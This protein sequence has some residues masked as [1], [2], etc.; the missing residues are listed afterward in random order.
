[1]HALCSVLTAI[2]RPV[3]VHRYSSREKHWA[4][5]VYVFA[6]R[7]AVL[8]SNASIDANIIARD[9]VRVGHGSTVSGKVIGVSGTVT[10]DSNIVAAGT[11]YIEI[12]KNIVNNG[13]VP[14]PIVPGTIFNF[15][16]SGVNGTIQVPA[17]GCSP[18]IQV[19]AGN[20]TITEAVRVNTALLGFNLSPINRF[21][22]FNP[23]LQQLV[24]A[25][26]AGDVNDQTVATF[27]NQTTRTGTIEI[28]KFAALATTGRMT[29]DLPADPD[30][31][32]F[33]ITPFRV[34]PARYFRYR[35]DSARDRSR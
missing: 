10:T 3:I 33:F 15:T 14:D 24:V 11:G 23:A 4:T 18:P 28:C 13:P 12:C 27:F 21:V 1:M 22:S 8:G 31:T 26:P 30:V 34:L 16:I 32:G 2:S 6:S 35:S 5:N 9:S 20:V 19:A 25:V 17:G 29:P 7:S